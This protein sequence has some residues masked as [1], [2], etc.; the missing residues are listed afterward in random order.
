MEI[1]DKAIEE[2]AKSN[3][4]ASVKERVDLRLKKFKITIASQKLFEYDSYYP[5]VDI[6]K[7]KAFHDEFY[8]LIEETNFN[9]YFGKWT[10]ANYDHLLSF[11]VT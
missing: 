1:L 10:N 7:K 6:N 11:R 3:E 9:E 4:V 8:G 2:N 5:I